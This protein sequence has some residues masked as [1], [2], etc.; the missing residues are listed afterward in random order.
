MERQACQGRKRGGNQVK[1]ARLRSVGSQ[2]S[3]QTKLDARD[4]QPIW[5][6]RLARVESQGAIRSNRHGCQVWAHRGLVG[7]EGVATDIKGDAQL[8][9]NATPRLVWLPRAAGRIADGP[10]SV[11]VGLGVW[12]CGVGSGVWECGVKLEAQA[13]RRRHTTGCDA[14]DA[15]GANA[16]HSRH[17]ASQAGG[18]LDL[19]IHT[20]TAAAEAPPH[21]RHRHA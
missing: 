7:V 1:P 18:W 20:L 21:Q 14:C 13:F 9:V 17:H 16:L 3:F 5:R 15:C 19:S 4:G 10:Q 8:G 11:M 12:E 6:D 2:V